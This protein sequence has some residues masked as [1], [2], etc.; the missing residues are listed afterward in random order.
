VTT[1]PGRVPLRVGPLSTVWRP[2]AVAVPL[3]GFGALLLAMAVSVGRGDFPIGLGDVFAT[4]FGGGDAQTRLIVVELRLPRALVGALVGAAFGLAG[5]ITQAIAR[6]PLASP[7]VLGVTSG[8]SVGAVAVIVLAGSYGGIS[9]VAGKVGVPLVALAGGLIAAIIVYALAWRRGIE[10]YRLVLVGVGVAGVLASVTSWL[11][12]IAEVTDAG[13]AMVWLTGS[14]H[15]RGW[16]HVQ[17]VALTLAVLVPAALVLAYTLGALQFD[18]DTARGLGVRIEAA[19]TAL[20]L[21]AVGLASVATAAA[22][23]ITFVALVAPQLAQRTVG[24]ARPPLIG[25]AVFGAVLTVCADLA[26]RSL[27]GG[28]EL[29]VGVLTAAL[30]APYLLYLLVRRREARA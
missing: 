4:L 10:G 19:R 1:V 26:A 17:P 2:R 28:F 18:D 29:P 23:P 12:M 3:L 7:D 24:T 25:A 16:E 22:G 21:I 27:F 9:G 8:A 6:N 20:L 13:R 15:A 30:G 11:L 14:L 5:A